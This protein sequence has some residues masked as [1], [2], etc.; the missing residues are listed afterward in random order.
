MTIC[1]E[2]SVKS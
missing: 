2:S 1:V